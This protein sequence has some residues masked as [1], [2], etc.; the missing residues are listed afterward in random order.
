MAEG[1]ERED[2]VTVLG[3]ADRVL[4]LGGERAVLGHGG[5]AVAE[6]LHLPAAEIDHRLHREEHAGPKLRAGAGLAVVQH[7][8]RV[9]EDPPD[10]VT[11]EIAHHGATL[12]LGIALDRVADVAQPRA[13]PHLGDAA[14][15]GIVGDVDE[16]ARLH[17]RLADI[18]HAA[19]VPVP[20][21]EDHGHV[22]VHDV[23]LLQ[24]LVAG[25]A[26]ADDVIDRGADGFW[27]AAIAERRRHRTVTHDV[28]VAERVEGVGGDTG[29]DHRRQRIEHLCRKPPGLAH[30]L[31]L[32]GPVG[33]DA[34]FDDLRTAGSAGEVLRRG[35]S[36]RGHG[37]PRLLA[38]R[39]GHPLDRARP[40]AAI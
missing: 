26:V 16:P 6:Q 3:D 39:G 23:A 2:L 12:A 13:G 9:V 36:R 5:P 40:P 15:R 10:A 32:L 27:V 11:A 1:G 33:L 21:V 17:A 25:D 35:A 31:E 28:V 4:E 8:R 18:E 14:H 30:R 22:D 24:P 34:P 38:M 29:L 7:V 20:A 19:R 37:W